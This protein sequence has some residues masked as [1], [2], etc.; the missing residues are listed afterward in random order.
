LKTKLYIA[1]EYEDAI[2]PSRNHPTDAGHDIYCY[3]TIVVPAK[4][5]AQVKTGIRITCDEGYWWTFK[6]RSSMGY[7]KQL[8]AYSGV[9][10]SHFTN[11][12]TVRMYNKSDKDYTINKGDKFCQVVV[13]PLPQ[14]ELEIIDTV[15][16]LE[17]RFEFGR[18]SAC[19]GSSGK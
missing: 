3:E 17:D 6:S 15:Q 12:T 5:T 10:D 2:I 4:G 7:V 8:E 19:W 18:G 9:M 13:I 16:E 1:R 11:D 14:V